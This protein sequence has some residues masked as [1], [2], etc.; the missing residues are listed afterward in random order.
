MT[1]SQRYRQRSVET[2]HVNPTL[3]AVNATTGAFIADYEKEVQSSLAAA[4]MTDVVT[5][6]YLKRSREG[7]VFCNGMTQNIDLT[8]RMKYFCDLENVAGTTRY[9]MNGV[10]CD[11]SLPLLTV[12]ALPS[13]DAGLVSQA[14][15]EANANVKVADVDLMVMAAE[16]DE[17]VRLL[18]SIG[19]RFLK[20]YRAFRRFNFKAL[21]KMR[22]G[23]I[24]DQEALRQ[25]WLEYRYGIR[26]I[27]YDLKG[28]YKYLKRHGELAARHT[29]RASAD[30]VTSSSTT[31]SYAGIYPYPNGTMCRL[32]VYYDRWTEQ[33][34]TVRAGVLYATEFSNAFTKRLALL[35]VDRPMSSAWD[36]IPF[37]FIVDWFVSIG[38]FV[39]SWEPKP[40]CNMLASWSVVTREAKAVTK[41]TSIVPY[42]TTGWVKCDTNPLED[43]YHS[44][45]LVERTAN[46]A[47]PYLPSLNVKLSAAK[48]L[49]LAGIFLRLK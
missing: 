37:S 10:A 20:V 36:L 4:D 32:K 21:R 15:T 45:K 28:I 22:Q 19:R 35:G 14:I 1:A 42:Y 26:P 3:H 44:V 41:V 31:S 47:L 27:Y 23:R 17:S 2:R 8:Q 24:S 25:A 16:L 12:P 5:P 9:L 43:S 49:D 33:S 7:Q 29:A 38:P 13:L 18:H 39:A 48:L 46:P 6:Q 30:S 11:V 34:Q 40:G